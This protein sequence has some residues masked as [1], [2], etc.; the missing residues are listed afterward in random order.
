MAARRRRPSPTP[1]SRR[2]SIRLRAPRPGDLGWVVER[3]G[4]LYA[5]EYGYDNR[6]EALVARIAADFVEQR[7]AKRHRCWIAEVN[8]VRAGSVFLV[9]LKGRVAK[10]RLLLVEPWA[11][12]AGVGRRLVRQ[13]TTFARRAGYTAIE[14]WTQAELVAARRLYAAEG[15][16]VVSKKTHRSFGPSAVAEVWRLELPTQRRGSG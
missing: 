6:F 14:L 10:L 5:E 11:R 4:A 7:D 1:R 16:R 13:C 3:H 12:G 15:Y 2:P 9:R 8:G